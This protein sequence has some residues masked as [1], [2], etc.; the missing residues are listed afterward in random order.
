ML[1]RIGD[2][3][4][5]NLRKVN[6]IKLTSIDCTFI[7]EGSCTLTYTFKNDLEIEKVLSVIKTLAPDITTSSGISTFYEA[8]Q[9]Q[10]SIVTGAYRE[11]PQD[12]S[13][14]TGTY[15]G[16][17]HEAAKVTKEN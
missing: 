7:M 10:L 15:K 6:G 14:I 3:F 9:K 8:L 2:E 13:E 16:K 17:L 12:F 4:V 11:K 1:V 5:I